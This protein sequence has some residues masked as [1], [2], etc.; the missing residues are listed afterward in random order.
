LFHPMEAFTQF[1]MPGF[2][3]IEIYILQKL[4][5]A[6]LPAFFMAGAMATFIPKS[7]II[8]YLSAGVKPWVSYPI[9]VVGGGVLSVCACGILPLFQ[10]IYQRGAGIGPAITFLFAGPAINI[11]AILFTYQLL[12]SSLGHARILY[13]LVLA[14]LLGAIFHFLFEGK[15]KRP[16]VA[17]MALLGSGRD[18]RISVKVGIFVLLMIMV[19]T[20]PISEIPWSVKVPVNGG[21]LA[22]LTMLWFQFLDREE[23][24]DWLDKSWF[25]IRNIVPKLVLGVFLIGVLEPYAKDF[26]VSQLS[27]NSFFSCLLASIIGGLLYVGTILGVV[28]VKGLVNLGMPDGPA[29]SLL[30][31]GPS[32]A[33]PSMLVIASVCGKKIALS[34]ALLVITLSAICGV[35]F[36]L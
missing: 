32:I 3:A 19:M 6:F 8:K 1:I 26:M 25:L 14:L 9:A 4:G 35:V 7:A 5:G 33:L 36:T 2:E 29:L 31:A 27:S 28:A 15:Q 24:W 13:V 16:V 10:T 21:C 12:G 34:F 17:Q 11:I 18:P 20:L 30:L 23:A 22:I